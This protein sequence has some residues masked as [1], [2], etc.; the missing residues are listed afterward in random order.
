MGR[1]AIIPLAFRISGFRPQGFRFVTWE[2]SACKL[3][4]LNRGVERKRAKS[5]EPTLLT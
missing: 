5:Y 4:A 1:T 3:P 2:T